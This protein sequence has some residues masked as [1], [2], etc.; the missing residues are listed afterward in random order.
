MT[1]EA[2][3]RIRFGADPEL[4][5][6]KGVVPPKKADGKTN[7]TVW[8]PF[9]ITGLI[10][11]T[12][13]KPLPLSAQLPGFGGCSIPKNSFIQEDGAALEFNVN[14]SPTIGRLF[15]DCNHIMSAIHIFAERKGLGV[16]KNCSADFSPEFKQSTPQA[17]VI[18]CD[19]DMDAYTNQ[20]RKAPDAIA[21]SLTRHAGGHFH[22]GYDKALVPP[23]VVV[24]FL[25]LFL[26]LPSVFLDKQGLRRRF[27]GQA[28]SYREKDY[29]V[30]YRTPSNWWL[31][32]MKHKEG[33]PQH[34]FEGVEDMMH[35]LILNMDVLERVYNTINWSDVQGAINEENEKIARQIINFGAKTQPALFNRAF[36]F[37][38]HVEMTRT[39]KGDY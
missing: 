31:P 38:D 29:G 25:D 7:K 16:Y 3:K 22:V 28:G 33:I 27:Y 2:L 12:K 21:A 18:G 5:L 20:L 30:E 6:Q 24:Q 14:P 34:L 11:G 9:P 19:P 37:I 1:Q 23:H 17:F 13:Y 26:G 15:T 36:R 8:S 39:K 35:D 32:Y 4:F 10:G